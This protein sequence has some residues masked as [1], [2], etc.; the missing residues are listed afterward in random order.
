M[1]LGVIS[2][3]LALV[4]LFFF[5]NHTWFAFICI[6]RQDFSKRVIENVFDA[7]K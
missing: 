1:N 7:A 4:F 6:L 3:Y 2:G 5:Q